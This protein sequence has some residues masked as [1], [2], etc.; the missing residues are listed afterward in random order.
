MSLG[1]LLRRVPF[2]SDMADDQLEQLVG[3]GRVTAAAPDEVMFREGDDAECLYVVLSGRVRIYLRHATGREMELALVQS[4]EFFGEMALLDGGARSAS[5]ICVTPSSFFVLDRAGFLDLLAH[6][7]ASLSRLLAHLTGNVRRMTG[8]Y[9]QEELARQTLRADMELARHRSLAQLVAGVAHEVNTP[10]GIISTA[11]SVIRRELTSPSFATLAAERSSKTA[12][13]DALEATEL[14]QKHV[15]RAH[16]LIQS[17]KNVSASESTD[18]R[19]PMNLREALAET[20]DL[21]KINA[22]KARLTVELDAALAEGET[23]WV[24]YRGHLSR[25]VLNLLTNVERYAYPEGAG[26]RVMISLAADHDRTVPCFLITVRDFG[27]G[28]APEHLPRVCEPFFTTGRG[29]GG[30]GLGL[31]IVHNLVT[32]VLQGTLA[33]ESEPGRGTAVRVTV[34][35][36]VTA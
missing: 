13:E 33:V 4:G 1:A 27:R 14:V 18:A 30:T 29:R 5:A 36:T 20:L 32:S 15:A 24:G 9:F 2:L 10:L 12:L 7:P 35:Q 25:V 19:E 3:R 23:T 34:P 8:R 28:I 31:A 21:F 22:R 6:S 16:A 17:F 11:A 26:G